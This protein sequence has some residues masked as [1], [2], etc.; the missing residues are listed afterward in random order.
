MAASERSYEDITTAHLE[1]LRQ[2]A[3]A[4]I[5]Q[6]IHRYPR[7]MSLQDMILAVAL[8]Q[9]AALHYVN[10]TNGVKDFDV[11]TFFGH[12][13]E[14]TFPPRRLVHRRFPDAPPSTT[15]FEG[16]RI[17]LI[18]RSLRSSA[19]SDPRDAI[20]TY[21]SERRTASARFLAQKAVV[22]LRPDERLGEVVWQ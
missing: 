20:R 1:T 22:L 13:P 5:Q 18:G 6:F 2:I 12:H 4:D 11:W 14:I 8:C 3:H 19:G 10:G 16:R 9:G 15:P 21:L 7:Y 17:D